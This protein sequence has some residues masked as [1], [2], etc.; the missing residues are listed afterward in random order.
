[1]NFMVD[2]NPFRE[3]KILL[4]VYENNLPWCRERYEEISGEIRRIAF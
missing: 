2:S 4:G 3:R 1:M